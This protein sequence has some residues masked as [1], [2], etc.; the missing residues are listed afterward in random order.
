MLRFLAVASLSPLLMAQAVEFHFAPKDGT[1]F[2]ETTKSHR[3]MDNGPTRMDDDVTISAATTIHKTPNGYAITR[4]L[5]TKNGNQFE[6]AMNG[7]PVTWSVD[8]GGKFVGASG[9]E[10]PL[11]D[12]KAKLPE[13]SQKQVSE[14]LTPDT[15]GSRDRREW[16][17]RIGRLAG[18]TFQ[19]YQSWV[20]DTDVPGPNGD[21][22]PVKLTSTV[23]A[24]AD[25]GA[26]QCAR[27]RVESK[28][29]EGAPVE[30]QTVTEM[31]VDPATGLLY[32]ETLTRTAKIKQNDQ[33]VAITE[34]RD[35]SYQYKAA[36]R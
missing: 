13:Q 11:S 17:S 33:T 21:P 32:G 35:T 9:Y 10:K 22:M 8:G 19:L 31:L 4:I 26:G 2:T 3:T 25:C 15:L 34:K 1:T 24:M 12:F 30:M 36:Q 20:E 5:E 14:S 27:V 16:E 6:T 23:T 18:K 29:G 28:S 7:A